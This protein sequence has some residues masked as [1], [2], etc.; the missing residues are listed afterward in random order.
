MQQTF[1]YYNSFTQEWY[2]NFR[3]TDEAATHAEAAGV[4][5]HPRAAFDSSLL[6][7]NV[8][9]VAERGRRY[10]RETPRQP[11]TPVSG[12]FAAFQALGQ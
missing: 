5:T 9:T 8:E 2:G 7:I 3:T 4:T 6:S 11:Q 1:A 12:S 10:A